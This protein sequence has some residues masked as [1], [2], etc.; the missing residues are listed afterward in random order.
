MNVVNAIAFGLKD[1]VEDSDIEI[2]DD[3]TIGEFVEDNLMIA[4]Q[5]LAEVAKIT[6]GKIDVDFL[7]SIVGSYMVS[8]ANGELEDE[9]PPPS[10]IF[11]TTMVD[12][13]E[14]YVEPTKET[15]EEEEDEGAL[16]DNTT[17]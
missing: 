8:S 6:E 12:A 4:C 9:T 13:M 1:Y 17:A 14:N 15:I 2:L 10:E 16:T 7:L 5:S 11:D 3:T